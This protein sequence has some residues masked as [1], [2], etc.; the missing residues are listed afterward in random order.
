MTIHLVNLVK[1]VDSHAPLPSHSVMVYYLHRDGQQWGPYDEAT[2]RSMLAAQQVLPTDLIWNDQMPDWA[3]VESVF[4]TSTP[5]PVPDPIPAP[6]PVVTPVPATTPVTAAGKSTIKPPEKPAVEAKPDKTET[7][8]KSSLPKIA[9]ITVAG[10]VVI[11][12][13]LWFFVFR[14]TETNLSALEI[15]DATA[16]VYQKGSSEPFS[17]TAISKYPSGKLKV[18]INF[19]EGKEKGTY[20]IWHENGKLMHQAN[21]S[22][23]AY[24]GKVKWWDKKGTLLMESSFSGDQETLIKT[25]VTFEIPFDIIPRYESRTH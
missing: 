9:A 5:T 12:V 21:Y 3:T 1:N 8:K 22:N 23:G 6:T 4:P 10:L 15:D 19:S 24:S 18:E 25:N 7:S 20:S 14:S 2:L 11:G 16:T 17:G 13:A